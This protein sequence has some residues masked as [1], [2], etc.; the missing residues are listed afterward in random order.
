M[1]YVEVKN[2]ACQ[3]V[4]IIVKTGLDYV[5]RRFSAS[6]AELRSPRALTFAGTAA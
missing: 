1:Q 2:K 3:I 5:T 6:S 4:V